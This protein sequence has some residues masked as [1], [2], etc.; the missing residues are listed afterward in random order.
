MTDTD[1][2]EDEV[3][4][5]GEGPEEEEGTPQENLITPHR[6]EE[7][8]DEFE[9][10]NVGDDKEKRQSV[11]KQA[12]DNGLKEIYNEYVWSSIKDQ[13]RIKQI[14]HKVKFVKE[15]NEFGSFNRPDF[16]NENCWEAVLWN[17]LPTFRKASDREKCVKWMT[18][19][20]YIRKRLS[21]YKTNMAMKQKKAYI[22]C[23]CFVCECECECV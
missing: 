12:Y 15:G 5:T 11:M 9:D 16:T 1:S 10:T 2:D 19:L 8:E 20:P 4:N 18:Y 14:L 3:I 6:V 17:A 7:E 23:K 22:K 21:D 13:I